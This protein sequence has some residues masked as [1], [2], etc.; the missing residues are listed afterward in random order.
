MGM[1]LGCVVPMTLYSYQ[2]AAAGYTTVVGTP[3]NCN[4]ILACYYKGSRIVGS[5]V[6]N[7]PL[8]PDLVLADVAAQVMVYRFNDGSRILDDTNSSFTIQVTTNAAGDITNWDM[9]AI[10]VA[11]SNFIRTSFLATALDRAVKPGV[12]AQAIVRGSWVRG[13][14]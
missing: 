4:P 7:G 2:G 6:F 8:A 10:V 14:F 9:S 1:P 12:S 5:V 3:P 13:T 11:G